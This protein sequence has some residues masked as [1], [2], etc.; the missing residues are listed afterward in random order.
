MEKKIRTLIVDDEELARID[1][2][3]M[4]TD[5]SSIEIVGEASTIKEAKKAILELKP[6]VIFLD[7]EFPGESGFDLLNMIDES[8]KIVFITAFDEF[9]IR[10]FDVNA[11]DYLLK[12]VST[13][14]L[15]QTIKKLEAGS[16]DL[17]HQDSVFSYDD[18]VFIAVN[19]KHYFI[20]VSSIIRI[21]SEGKYPE[22]LTTTKIKGL[23]KKSLQEWE[24][25]LPEKRF[26]RIH[27][28]TII[29]IE[30]V[31]KIVKDNISAYSV[32][33]KGSEEKYQISRRYT[34]LLKKKI[35]L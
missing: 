27:R 4:L 20:R 15:A 18:Q 21:A 8:I 29:N 28:S 22:I 12:P 26:I 2:R 34:S 24:K 6:D 16:L 19:Y 30:F 9:A 1:L 25:C 23:V 32:Y 10:A 11:C 33:M 13:K 17:K 14:R 3:H 35:V 31:E 5:H 7:I